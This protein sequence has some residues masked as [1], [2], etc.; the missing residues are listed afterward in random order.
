MGNFFFFPDR[1]FKED[2]EFRKAAKAAGYGADGEEAIWVLERLY[3]GIFPAIKF[4][5]QKALN[6][7]EV[8]MLVIIGEILEK[9]EKERFNRLPP[10]LA[11]KFCKGVEDYLEALGLPMVTVDT[12]TC[13]EAIVEAARRRGW[14]LRS[15]EDNK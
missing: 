14:K 8:K 9:F 10:E 3:D 7:P 5:V 1:K 6:E 13:D 2:L 12:E 4:L 11:E 15:L